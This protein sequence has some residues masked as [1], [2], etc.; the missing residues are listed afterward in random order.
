MFVIV[1]K[2]QTPKPKKDE[3]SKSQ[4]EKRQLSP[5]SQQKKLKKKD[6]KRG[7]PELFFNSETQKSFKSEKIQTEKIEVKGILGTTKIM[8]KDCGYFS[9]ANSLGKPW[10]LK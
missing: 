5:K 9:D 10:L 1:N 4:I 2:L 7:K 8:K 3:Q 6:L